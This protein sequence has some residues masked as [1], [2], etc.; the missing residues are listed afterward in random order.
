MPII[1]KDGK[2]SLL[3][4][5]NK[6]MNDIDLAWKNLN[7][8]H[9]KLTKKGVRNNKKEYVKGIA[10]KLNEVLEALGELNADIYYEDYYH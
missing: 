4:L 7:R 3:N 2:P 8:M 1:T 9:N 10:Y 6:D 5:S